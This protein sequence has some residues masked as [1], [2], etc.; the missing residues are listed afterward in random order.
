MPLLNRFAGAVT[1]HPF[2]ALLVLVLFALVLCLILMK[3]QLKADQAV[4]D[5]NRVAE[6][7]NRVAQDALAMLRRFK[8][9]VA[10]RE[11]DLR[12]THSNPILPLAALRALSYLLP[13]VLASLLCT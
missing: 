2:D 12:G 13:P 10:L 8:K 9:G 6:D 3:V 7:A 4:N 11:C 1:D 5:A